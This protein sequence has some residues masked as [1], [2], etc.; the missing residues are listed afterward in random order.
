[1]S[2]HISKILPNLPIVI[3]T[4]EQALPKSSLNKNYKI[5]FFGGNY[6]NIVGSMKVSASPKCSI[7]ANLKI[8]YLGKLWKK[9][10]AKVK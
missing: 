7:K 5:D 2:F 8:F 3:L 6:V 10:G 1:M 9:G 4:S